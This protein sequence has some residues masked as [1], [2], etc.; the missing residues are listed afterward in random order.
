MKTGNENKPKV[1]RKLVNISDENHALLKRA[2]VK[3]GYKLEWLTNT[4]IKQF[5]EKLDSN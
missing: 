4:A 1:P 2:S 5:I 3:H